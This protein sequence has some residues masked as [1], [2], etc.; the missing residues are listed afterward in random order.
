MSL[1]ILDPKYFS[2][3]ALLH[4]PPSTS[5]TFSSLFPSFFLKLCTNDSNFF[6]AYTYSSRSE[7]NFS[8]SPIYKNES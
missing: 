7:F 3:T 2:F 1:E 8:F 5:L 4:F 6:A